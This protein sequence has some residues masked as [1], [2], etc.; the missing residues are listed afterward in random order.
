[1][2]GAPNPQEPEPYGIGSDHWPG[3]GKVIEET[4]ELG[5]VL[6]K[7]FGSGGR[8]EH[9]SGDL[10]VMMRDEIA[11]VRAAL[12]FLQDENTVIGE[13]GGRGYMERRERWKIDLFCSWQRGDP[14]ELWP[15]PEQYDLPPRETAK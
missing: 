7:L 9:W 4:N 6:G 13:A 10:V 12:R 5:A 3:V 8:R 11:D 15:Q 1:M 14:P 2:S